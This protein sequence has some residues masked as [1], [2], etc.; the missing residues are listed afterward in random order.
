VAS[1]AILVGGRATRYGGRDKSALAVGGRTVLE[2]QVA[3]LTRVAADIMLI[4][5]ADRTAGARTLTSSS[6]MAVRWLPDRTPGLGPLAGLDAALGAAR[7]REVVLLAC[8]MPFVT[9]GLM[10]HLIALVD[11]FDAVVPRTARGDH[12][13]CG[14]YI[15]D[16]RE[17]VTRTLA[18]GRLAMKDLLPQL[19]VRSVSEE[20]L[21]PFGDPGRLLANV[22]TPAEYEELEAL[23]GHHR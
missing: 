20:E 14:V 1:A 3:E 9:S 15:R 23:Q 17:A 18:E 4:G 8:D 22:N 5:G 19:R 6:G 10:E 12:P 13:L 7:H 16:C 2:R 11:G 21:R